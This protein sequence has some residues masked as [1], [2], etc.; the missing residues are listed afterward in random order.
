MAEVMSI[1]GKCELQQISPLGHGHF[2]FAPI[3]TK[4][5]LKAGW[6][7]D[8]FQQEE[9]KI[10]LHYVFSPNGAMKDEDMIKLHEGVRKEA[11]GLIENIE[12]LAMASKTVPDWLGDDREYLRCVEKFS[13]KFQ[14][15]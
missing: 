10:K 9:V 12:I 15:V 2:V 6:K 3:R 8:V 13:S 11:E 1:E 4:R 14:R 5:F 7:S